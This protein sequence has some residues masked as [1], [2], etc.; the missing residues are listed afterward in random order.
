MSIT[1]KEIEAIAIELCDDIYPSYIFGWKEV[2]I[3]VTKVVE[4]YEQNHIRDVPK[5]VDK[6]TGGKMSDEI[7]KTQAERIT[8][9]EDA[10]RTVHGMVS[11][12][13]AYNG[14]VSIL[15][16]ENIYN[17]VTGVLNEED[18]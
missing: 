11:N 15:E 10:L 8:H 9:L 18:K 13:T 7:I 6:Q 17:Y 2:L 5:M 3:T 12:M 16:I 4:A 1:E 14:E